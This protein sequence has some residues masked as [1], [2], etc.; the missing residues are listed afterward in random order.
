MRVAQMIDEL[1]L[2]GGA[3]ALQETFAEAVQH[4]DIDLTIMT[5][6]DNEAD[7][8]RHFESLGV[9]VV[10]MHARRFSSP[11]RAARVVRFLREERFDLVHTHL[12]RS[13]IIGTGAARLVGTPT[14]ATLHNTRRNVRLHPGLDFMDTWALRHWTDRVIAVGWE[15][16]VANE[17]RLRGRH[18][19]IIPNAVA[20]CPDLAQG[21]RAAVRAELGVPEDAPLVIAVGRLNPQKAFPDLFEAFSILRD[22]GSNAQLRIAGRGR[23]EAELRGDIEKRKLG[24]H[25]QLL[26]LR[27]DVSRL[28]AASDVYVSSSIWEGLPVAT[29]EA[30]AAGLPVVATRV[31]D[32]PRIV[33][34]ETGS[35]VEPGRPAELAEALQRVLD[36]AELRAQQSRAARRRV[37]EDFLS[38]AWANKIL[39]LYREL[40]KPQRPIV[41]IRGGADAVKQGE[42]AVDGIAH[43]KEHRCA[44]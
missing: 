20:A 16:A 14:V 29:L 24:G 12:I 34:A 43:R 3:E 27:R 36:D 2:A 4:H 7:S 21:E 11:S 40:E 30:M 41:G 35:L 32:V 18:I 42:T 6:H 13:T 37:E 9:R 19:D 10:S 39:S 15:T 33:T 25:V 28:L 1:R 23:F 38:E 22:R 31:G 26:G 44:S 8:V 5:L 17:G